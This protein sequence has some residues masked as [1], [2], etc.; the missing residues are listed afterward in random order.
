MTIGQVARAAGVGVETVRFYERKGLVPVPPKPRH[1]Y[2][3]Y[4]P[5]TVARI[6]FIKRAQGLGFSLGEVKE[7]LEL[8]VGGGTPRARVRERAEAKLKEL[9]EKMA[10]LG[11]MRDALVQ[12]T[13]ACCDGGGGD[14]DCPILRAL[15]EQVR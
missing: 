2:R 14:D 1:G 10:A 12:L 9:D 7:L 8:R 13:R 5:E 11:R 4:A 6:R 15:E 3:Q